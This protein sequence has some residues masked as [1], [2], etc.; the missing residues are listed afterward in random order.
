MSPYL[1]PPIKSQ[2]IKSKL[3][4]CIQSIVA[5]NFLKC[6]VWVEPFCGT[7][8]VALN[9]KSSNY[10]LADI[11]PHLIQ[12]YKSLQN[13]DFSHVSVRRFL[14]SEAEKFTKIDDYYYIVRDR[15]N[16]DFDPLDFLLLNRSCFNGIIRFNK[17]GEFNVPFCKKK[18]RFRTQY[19]TKIT[20]QIKIF[21]EFL[22]NNNVLLM[23]SDFR[24][25][26][27]EVRSIKEKIVYCDPP[28]IDRHTDYYNNWSEKDEHDLF[29]LLLTGNSDFLLSTWHHNKYRY[30][31]YIDEL[32]KKF[33]VYT[34]EHFYHVG[35]KEK[36]RSPM[37][38]AIISNIDLVFDYSTKHQ[39][40][41]A[42]LL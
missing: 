27:E 29:D 42:Y 9:I 39:K 40:S 21:E 32:W 25:T 26:F 1:I 36:N 13:K 16:K 28:Y 14:V 33:F 5:E 30:N 24:T 8:V 7:G 22:S 12:F 18:E 20:N 31:K 2:G 35:G 38:E 41:Q 3:V 23:C 10:I 37:F 19:I 17:K 11:N 15:F 6:D 4:P 34:T